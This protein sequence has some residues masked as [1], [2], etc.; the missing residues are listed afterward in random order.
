[1]RKRLEPLDRRQQI[2]DAAIDQA[3]EQGFQNVT[4]EGIARK[5]ECS[6]GLVSSY[7]NTMSQLKRALMREA[8]RSEVLEIVAQGLVVGD[9]CAKKAPEEL[10]K[11]AI[12][13]VVLN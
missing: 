12:G 9:P 10:K 2:L 3:R 4:R 8:I 5:A 7:F 11:R 6:D 13:A 1:M